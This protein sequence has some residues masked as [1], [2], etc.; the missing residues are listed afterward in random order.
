MSTLMRTG[1]SVPSVTRWAEVR[2]ALGHAPPPPTLESVSSMHGEQHLAR[3]AY[4][5]I[6]GSW[7][8]CGKMRSSWTRSGGG[9]ACSAR[10]CDII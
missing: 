10:H 4:L 5:K 6:A 3:R 9:I 7:P 8:D 1:E 2:A